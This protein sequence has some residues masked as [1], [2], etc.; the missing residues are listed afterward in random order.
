MSRP[1]DFGAARPASHGPNVGLIALLAGACGGEKDGAIDPVADGPDA[2][3]DGGGADGDSS[4][5]DGS[6]SR[7]P[8]V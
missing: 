4:G 8:V 1:L 3:S 2:L 7:R 5:D 6:G